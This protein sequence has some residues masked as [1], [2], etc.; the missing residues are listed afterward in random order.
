[1]LYALIVAC[2]VGFWGILLLALAVRYVFRKEQLSRMLLFSLPLIY[3]LLLFITA[4]DLRR[5]TTATFAHGL[6]AAYVGFT[7]SS[8]AAGRPPNPCWLGTST[9][10]AA[11]CFGFSS[12]RR[13]A[14]QRRGAART[15]AQPLAQAKA[16]EHAA[17]PSSSLG[18]SCGRRA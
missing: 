10:L 16:H 6:A 1:M 4:T 9:P 13:G 5:G 15:D 11:S 18:V 2:E 8:W 7:V 17:Q 3:L 12:V 14:W